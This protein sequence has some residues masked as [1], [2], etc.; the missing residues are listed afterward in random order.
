VEVVLGIDHPIA[1]NLRQKISRAALARR[2]DNENQ[3]K[4]NINHLALIRV[5]NLI[6]LAATTVA[7]KKA[8]VKKIIEIIEEDG[9][10]KKR[11]SVHDSFTFVNPSFRV[12]DCSLP[13]KSIYPR[14]K[15]SV[16]AQKLE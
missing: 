13:L 10:S 1:K 3:P 11:Q 4:K 15:T 8:S 14:R 6:L 16:T 12:Q 7:M 2:T 5:F 9:A